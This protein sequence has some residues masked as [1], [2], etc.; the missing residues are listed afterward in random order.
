MQVVCVGAQEKIRV[1][2]VGNSITFGMWIR[3]RE[4]D[5]YLVVLG[6]LLGEKYEVRNFGISART[7]LNKGDHPYM[8]EQIYRDALAYNPDIVTIKLGTNDSKPDNWKYGSEF[9]DDLRTLIRSFQRLS[10]HPKI[11]L[12]LPIP[13]AHTQWGINDSTIVNGVIPAIEEVAKELNL[14]VIDL[15]TAFAPH[16]DL[17]PDA[18]HPNKEGAAII[19]EE[20]YKTI[21]GGWTKVVNGRMW[22]DENGKSVQA[23]GAGFVL[24]GDT[25]YMIGEDRAN[26]WQPD[27]NMYSSKDLQHWTFEGKIIENRKTH[28][29]LGTR[30]FIERP[31]ILWN[32]K[33]G[34]FVV[35]CHYEGRIYGAS[36]AAVFVSDKVTG[37]YEFVWGG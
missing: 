37:P 30:R 2:C 31:K 12:C 5:S 7:L 34:K 32:R 27:V 10:S 36:E 6:R 14:P 18:V 13:P 3:D 11:Y 8:N 35:W 9:K 25:W 28:P 1:A 23:H 33:T 21:S 20:L 22:I 17:L 4:H 29:D 24:V 26:S 15:H 16:T 19:A